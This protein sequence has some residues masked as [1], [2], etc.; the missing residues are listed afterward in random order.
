MFGL[1]VEG[2]YLNDATFHRVVDLMRSFL[3]AYHITPHELREA[4][5]LAATMH[6]SERIRPPFINPAMLPKP[7]GGMEVFV[8]EAK[9][10][11]PAMFGGLIDEP[12]RTA[13]GSAVDTS[14]WGNSMVGINPMFDTSGC[15]TGRFH[16]DGVTV[17]VTQVDKGSFKCICGIHEHPNRQRHTHTCNDSNYEFYHPKVTPTPPQCGEHCHLFVGTGNGYSVCNDCG[18]S[19]VY[20]NWAYN[21]K[22][23]MH[24]R[25]E[26][27]SGNQIGR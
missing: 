20:Y 14:K 22:P 11:T 1:D 5:I 9:D 16:S 4:A 13:T 26:D 19:D 6:E 27:S 3:S 15:E 17:T 25:A 24:I 18:M 23:M 2:R 21:K 7:W 12:M 10:I 8:D